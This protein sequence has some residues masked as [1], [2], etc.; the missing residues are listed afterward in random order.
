[1]VLVPPDLPPLPDPFAVELR[2]VEPKKET[3][4]LDCLTAFV[5]VID[6]NALLFRISNGFSRERL[7]AEASFIQG[8]DFS[9]F[10]NTRGRINWL[11]LLPAAWWKLGFDYNRTKRETQFQQTFGGLVAAQLPAHLR[12]TC[13]GG[14]TEFFDTSKHSFAA[15]YPQLDYQ[16]RLFGYGEATTRFFFQP[17]FR[18]FLDFS[19]ADQITFNP[20]F[21]LQPSISFQTPEKLWAVKMKFGSRI[22]SCAFDLA[23]LYNLRQLLRFDSLY[24]AQPFAELNPD[25][26]PPRYRPAI[27]LKIQLLTLELQLVRAWID[28]FVYWTD[29]NHDSLFEPHNH[30]VRRDGIQLSYRFQWKGMK[31]SLGVHYQNIVPRLDLIPVWTLTDT[32]AFSIKRFGVEVGANWVDRRP[33]DDRSLSPVFNLSSQI[34]YSV[35]LLK[36]FFAVDN[37]LDSKYEALPYRFHT[38]RRFS[39]GCL[40]SKAL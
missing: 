8:N 39:L 18:N 20:R 35:G 32:V 22:K 33:F 37:I 31:N 10:A 3:V 11:H 4:P 1:M 28:S 38:G 40:L 7:T 26:S 14:Y 23:V 24:C 17:D 6:P 5:S 29:S 19:L 16:F 27:T 34:N 30:D 25:L 12:L 9:P 13:P 15:L 21:T 2:I 36:F